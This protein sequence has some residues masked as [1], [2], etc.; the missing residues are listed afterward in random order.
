MIVAV[1][2]VDPFFHVEP[3]I[4]TVGLLETSAPVVVSTLKFLS[5]SYSGARTPSAALKASSVTSS[6]FAIAT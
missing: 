2:V 4:L 6:D 3:V 1:A 5:P